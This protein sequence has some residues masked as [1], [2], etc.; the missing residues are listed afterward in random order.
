MNTIYSLGYMA[1]T[2]EA[3]AAYVEQYDALVV[4]IRY[5][6]KSSNPHWGGMALRRR[7][8]DRYVY[9]HDY[10][11]PN[12]KGG[13]MT[14]HYPDGAVRQLRP[15]LERHNLILICA[16]VHSGSC[17]RKLAAEHLS[18]ATGA[19]VVHLPGK[20]ASNLASSPVENSIRAISLWQPWATLVVIGAKTLETRSWPTRYRGPLAIHATKTLPVIARTLFRDDPFYSVLVEAGYPSVEAL[21]LG[22]VLGTVTVAD[23]ISTNKRITLTAQERAFGDFSP[24]RYAWTLEDPVRFPVPIEARGGQG[25]WMWQM[26]EGVL[27]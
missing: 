15:L 22:A 9:C 27:V 11:N 23:C 25:V 5:N 13:P 1:S 3:L 2:P 18:A 14:L 24:D 7:Y 4:D 6:P 10:G 17:H 26:P 20:P 16:C 12:Y 21:P 19:P 8:G